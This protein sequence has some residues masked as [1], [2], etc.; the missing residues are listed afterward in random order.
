M[1][2][3]MKQTGVLPLGIMALFTAVTAHAAAEPT[4]ARYAHPT[5]IYGHGAVEDGEFATLE[6]TTA[7][8]Q[9]FDI[10]YANGVFEGPAPF[11]YDLDGDGVAEII[12]THSTFDQGARVQIFAQRERFFCLNYLP[13]LSH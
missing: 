11:V 4:V 10:S 2:A 8:G 9:M 12:A 6:V 13:F 5:D 7:S 1:G 3:M